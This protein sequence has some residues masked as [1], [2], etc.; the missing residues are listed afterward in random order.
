MSDKTED[1]NTTHKNI[2]R[3]KICTGTVINLVLKNR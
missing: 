3:Q 1:E 2:C